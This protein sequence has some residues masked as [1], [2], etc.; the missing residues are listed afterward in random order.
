MAKS[1]QIVKPEKALREDLSA[2]K[3][4]L[5][6]IGWEFSE[7]E[8]STFSG[9]KTFDHNEFT[10]R[11]DNARSWSQLFDTAQDMEEREK[12]LSAPAATENAIRSIDVA[13]IVPSPFEPQQRRRRHYD[14][15]SLESL[16]AS[17]KKRGLRQAI[18]VRFIKNSGKY[19]IVFGERRWRASQLAGLTSIKCVVERLTDEE[20][21]EFQLEEN[22]EREGL[23]PLDEAFY[24]KYY[25][26]HFNLTIPD[27]MA[28]FEK[29]EQYI[30]GRLKLNDLIPEG[31]RDVESGLLPLGHAK[32]IAKYASADQ[33]EILNL[34]T[35]IDEGIAPAAVSLA[36]LKA[37]IEENIVL[38]LA[39]APFDQADKRLHI[40]G[41]A[42]HECPQRSS[43]AP[44]LFADD[45]GAED[46][47]LN[48][49]CFHAKA[50]VFQKLQRELAAAN[51][52]NPENKPIEEL[53]KEVPVIVQHA[54]ARKTTEATIVNPTI[55]E[56]KE[57]DFWRPALT[58]ENR[59]TGYCSSD[60]CPVH[61]PKEILPAAERE[62][63]ERH[64]TNRVNHHVRRR[65]FT[66]TMSFFTNATAFWIY[67]DL[68]KLL[69]CDLWESIEGIFEER[70][71]VCEVIAKWKGVPNEGIFDRTDWFEFVETLDKLQQTQLLFIFT[72][73][74]RSLLKGALE[75]IA[76]DWTKLDF[77]LL[78]A[79][80]IH[81]LAPDEF[82]ARAEDYLGHVKNDLEAEKPLF[83]TAVETIDE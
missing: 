59:T 52:P 4:E 69:L 79:Q 82:K 33:E 18:S 38:K 32:T 45:F 49:E 37:H 26:D 20:T 10:S 62:K 5:E 25:L 68:V 7:K 72:M 11:I 57:C 55:V 12:N 30:R 67:D 28:K 9:S 39:H 65:V 80:T 14:Q 13:D 75:T 42:C 19:E 8:N 15:A 44:A 35:Y 77:K 29:D 58:K 46:R 40:K 81:E 76:K 83:W 61:H 66:E 23:T 36:D 50:R 34:W 21:L 60:E 74:R 2:R 51:L 31:V 78:E 43:S 64:F 54:P 3:T 63:L 17:I 70:R 16:A 53:A 27:L 24:F 1:K 48:R 22:T 41:L 56:R 47:C 71:F 6:K 73:R